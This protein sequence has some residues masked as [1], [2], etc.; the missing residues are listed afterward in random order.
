MKSKSPGVNS[1][2]LV[3]CAVERICRAIETAFD[4]L[5]LGIK[6]PKER[7]RG[8]SHIDKDTEGNLLSRKRRQKMRSKKLDEG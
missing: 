8:G 6:K 3:P 1:I 2:T 5:Y 4:D 7:A